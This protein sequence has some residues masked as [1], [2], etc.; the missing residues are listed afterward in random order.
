MK[1]VIQARYRERHRT[2][3][4]AK[5]RA[6]YWSDLDKTRRRQ[7]ESNRKQYWKNRKRRLAANARYREE[8]RDQLL[9]K[10]REW[11]KRNLEQQRA[12][13]RQRS[14]K[15]YRSGGKSAYMKAWR[16][17]NPQKAR[18]FLRA[19]FHKRR[20]LSHG[21]S[22]TANEWTVLLAQCG[23]VCAYCGADGPLTADH[24]IPLSRGGRNVIENIVPACKSCNS[25]KHTMTEDE[26][27]AVLS[28][29]P[30][31]LAEGCSGSAA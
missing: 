4:N 9:A 24:R 6:R 21:E 8:N 14:L 1:R 23:D 18:E 10:Q 28:Q 22:F 20:V 3:L 26:F 27:R 13:D 11:R 7:S 25:R 2:E 12:Q 17:R 5:Q 31:R 19:S 30:N 15:R 29:Q 16:Q